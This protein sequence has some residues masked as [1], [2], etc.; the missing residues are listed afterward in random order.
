VELNAHDLLKII[1]V[2]NLHADSP[3]PDWALNSLSKAPYVVVRR[4]DTENRRIPVGIRGTQRGQR[5]AAWVYPENIIEVTTPYMLTNSDCWKIKYDQNPPKT[6]YCLRQLI[7]VFEYTALHWG[8]TGSTAF[9]L[10]TGVKTLTD[11]SDLDLV[12]QV[13]NPLSRANAQSLLDELQKFTT[14]R[15]DIQLLTPLGGVSLVEYAGSA[16]VLVKSKSGPV[17]AK[18]SALWT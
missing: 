14:V 1:A 2:E 9:E 13:P 18:R 12:I 6:V 3:L 5:I 11:S 8:P 10:T 7:S 4:E 17:L 15:L 16:T